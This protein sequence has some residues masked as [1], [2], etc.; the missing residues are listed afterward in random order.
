MP[1]A[2]TPQPEDHDQLGVLM[3]VDNDGLTALELRPMTHEDA[4][5]W[6]LSWLQQR[7]FRLEY[8]PDEK[9]PRTFWVP[10]TAFQPLRKTGGELAGSPLTLEELCSKKECNCVICQLKRQMGG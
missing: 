9:V 7:S 3:T 5:T 8:E 10:L 6:I 4:E 2:P 1:K